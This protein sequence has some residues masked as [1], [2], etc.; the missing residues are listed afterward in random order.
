MAT[1][2]SGRKRPRRG[3]SGEDAQLW[4]RVAKTAQPLK[5]RPG[6]KSAARPPGD[7]E[8]KPPADAPRGKEPPQQRRRQPASEPSRA[9]PLATFDVKEARRL[10]GGRLAIDAR[11]DLHGLTQRRAYARLKS[12]LASAQAQGHRHVLVITGK[13]LTQSR[14]EPEPFWESSDRGVLKRLVP[15]WL[16]EPEFR[17]VVVS[18]TTAQRKHGGEGALYVR[19]RRA[20]R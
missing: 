17:S 7:G 9:A 19:L 8:S 1:D 6:R 3:L 11:V 5:G 14:G 16:S 18:F 12:F 2:G 13:G 20:R 15:Q 10:A 4:E